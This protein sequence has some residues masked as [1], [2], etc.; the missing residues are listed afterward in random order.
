MEWHCFENCHPPRN[1]SFFAVLC[2]KLNSLSLFFS[3]RCR[4]CCQPV[5]IRLKCQ[6]W[7]LQL[8][9]GWEDALDLA[10][11]HTFSLPCHRMLQCDRERNPIF[12]DD[13]RTALNDGKLK[14]HCL[15]KIWWLIS[16]ECRPKMNASH[17]TFTCLCHIRWSYNQIKSSWWPLVSYSGNGASYWLDLSCGFWVT[18]C[19]RKA[20]DSPASDSQSNV[21]TERCSA[22]KTE[23]LLTTSFVVF[24][25]QRNPS[26]ESGGEETERGQ[27]SREAKAEMEIKIR[28][29]KKRQIWLKRTQEE[30]AE[31]MIKRQKGK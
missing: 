11:L 2:L 14:I 22:G 5:L 21:H 15:M 20:D 17:H 28:R 12:G 10:A 6:F 4:H 27:N 30:K 19:D 3:P 25:R 9:P 29:R 7:H 13:S 16:Q 18:S 26:Q 23:D 1:D 24:S 8:W 31:R